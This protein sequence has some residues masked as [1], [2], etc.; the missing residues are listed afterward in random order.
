MIIAFDSRVLSSRFRDQGT[1]V[2]AKQLL[3]QF[4]RLV[5]RDGGRGICVRVFACS[6]CSNDANGFSGG[7]GFDLVDAEGLRF[8]RLWRFGGLTLAAL[9]AKADLIFAP[10]PFFPMGLIPAV[11]T[12]HDA[13]PVKFPTLSKQQNAVARSL[14]WTAGKFS[15]RI[16]TDSEWS[17]QDLV[18]ICGLPPEK[19]R[20]V[21]L[22]YDQGI[23]NTGPVDLQEQ[24]ALLARYGIAG[25][26]I[27]HH[28]VVQPRK[29]LQRLIQA[30][31]MVLQRQ[32]SLDLGLVLAGPL[33]WQYEEVL[34][35]AQEMGGRVY[36]VGRLPDPEMALMLKAARLCVIPS[37]YEGFCLPMIEAMACG[38]PT[39]AS[40]AS[41]LPEVS[42]GVLLY[43]DPYSVEEMAHTILRVLNDQPLR[44]TIVRSGCQRAAEFGW[45]RCARETLDVLQDSYLGEVVP[46]GEVQ[47]V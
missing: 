21:Y 33:G 44:E 19:V 35:T 41:C 7:P 38:V 24:K 43:F 13:T 36:L 30:Y 12:I 3:I 23:F 26:Y 32:S 27:F 39:I 46:S 42:G 11:T 22:G 31:R 6:G 4:R 28:G 45:E 25:P 14:L 20:V 47:K 15:R 5:E 8:D 10:S 29:N 17:K 9:R 34:R 37:L 1:Y 16:I 18:S 2:Y 40:N